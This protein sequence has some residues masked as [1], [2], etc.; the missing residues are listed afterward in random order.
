M[1]AVGGGVISA[2]ASV[3]LGKLAAMVQAP[4]VITWS[5]KGAFP[6]DDRLYVLDLGLC[7]RDPTGGLVIASE[8]GAYVSDFATGEWLLEGNSLLC[9]TPALKEVLKAIAG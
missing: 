1:I 6:E 8:A 9:C 2:E 3:E 5:G 7:R 4:V